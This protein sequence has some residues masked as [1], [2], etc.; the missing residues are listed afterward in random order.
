MRMFRLAALGVFLFG[1]LAVS[2]ARADY[3]FNGSGSS[4]DL[5]A[6]AE[7][8]AFDYDFQYGGTQSDWGSP[9]VDAGETPY[10]QS[11]AAYGFTVTFT[12]GGTIDASSVAIG[13][14]SACAG[15]TG[16]GTTFCTATNDIWQAFVTGPDSIEFLAQSPTF[17]ETT[18]EYYFVNV[19]F[20]GATP[21][22]FSGSWLT[23]FTPTPSPE[24]STLLSLGIGLLGLVGLAKRKLLA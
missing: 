6:G 10:T 1:A 22:G 4:G 11:E 2:A 24:S 15:S 16:G 19:F 23:E 3:A 13:N 12:G 21:T 17:D 7:S 5:T 8:W 20:D 18:D 9:G 14:A